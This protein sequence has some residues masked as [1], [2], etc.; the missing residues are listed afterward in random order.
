MEQLPLGKPTTYIDIYTPS[1]LCPLERQVGRNDYPEVLP[2]HGVDIWNAYEL[3]WL[4]KRGKPVV[5]VASFYIPAKSRF[6]IESKSLKLY[7]NSFNQTHFSSVQEVQEALSSDLKVA[8]QQD[9]PLLM[10]CNDHQA[11]L[12]AKRLMQQP[13]NALEA[14]MVNWGVGIQLDGLD[15]EVEQYQHP[16]A[17]MLVCDSGRIVTETLVSHLLKTNCPVTGQPDWATILVRYCGAEILPTSM[18]R[19]LIAFRQHQDFHEACVERIYMD[20]W[21]QCKPEMLS[22]YARYTRRGG[23]DIN[24]FRS[25]SEAQM[26]NAF[27]PRQ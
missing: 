15:V 7:L 20:I 12:H 17:D 10:Q 25:S 8:V 16:S 4:N 18:L 11:F 5:A 3:S 6:T 13:P 1:L 14:T 22:V 23:I 9:V 19:Y 27:A 2:F 26:I 21:R 24:P